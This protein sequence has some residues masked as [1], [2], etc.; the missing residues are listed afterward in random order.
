M[1]IKLIDANNNVLELINNKTIIA[2]KFEKESGK[3][4]VV[5]YGKGYRVTN[6]VKV[7]VDDV[8]EY[9]SVDKT[10]TQV[11]DKYGNIWVIRVSDIISVRKNENET[12]ITI[13]GGR[14]GKKLY[15]I[16]K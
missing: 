11:T 1:K 12:A 6:Y 15:V 16:A 7:E 4:A 3:L 2:I 9:P 8:G 14:R 5:R 13:K 10:F